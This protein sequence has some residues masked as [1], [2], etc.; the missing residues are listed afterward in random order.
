[1]L[2]KVTYQKSKKCLIKLPYKEFKKFTIS[3]NSIKDVKS[4]YAFLLEASRTCNLSLNKKRC[5]IVRNLE[6]V[7]QKLVKLARVSF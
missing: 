7:I 3:K 5:S 1:M 6:A 2:K 4:I